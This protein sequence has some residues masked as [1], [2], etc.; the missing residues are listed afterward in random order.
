MPKPGFG[1]FSTRGLTA[2]CDGSDHDGGIRI[3][4]YVIVFNVT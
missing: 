3:H 2:D 4:G 1:E